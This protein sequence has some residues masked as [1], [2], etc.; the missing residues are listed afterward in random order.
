MKLILQIAFGVFLGS[1]SS[2]LLTDLWHEHRQ[3]LAQQEAEKQR[4]QREKQREEQG[5]Q[6]R[7]LLLK[8]KQFEQDRSTTK[9]PPGFIPDDAKQQR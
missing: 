8:S 2:Q 6:I 5:E 1:L 7:Q 3:E 9:P 4:L